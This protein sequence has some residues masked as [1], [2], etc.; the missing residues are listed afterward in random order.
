MKILEPRVSAVTRF[1]SLAAR[2]GPARPHTRRVSVPVPAAPRPSGSPRAPIRPAGDVPASHR[3]ERSV[4][5]TPG[6]PARVSTSSAAPRRD[7][8]GAE[9]RG[10]ARGRTSRGAAVGPQTPCDTLGRPRGGRSARPGLSPTRVRGRGANTHRI[11][12][13]T[14]ISGP[15]SH[16]GGSVLEKRSSLS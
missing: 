1:R 5:A 16:A 7:L 10:C 14:G 6:L 15:R 4:A 2:L 8:R 9:G 11:G 13:K 12:D 3:P